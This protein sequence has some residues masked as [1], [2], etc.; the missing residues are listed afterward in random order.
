M[1]AATA[2]FRRPIDGAVGAALRVGEDWRTEVNQRNRNSFLAQAILSY[3]VNPY[4]RFTAVPTYLSRVNGFDSTI[5]PAPV[6]GDRSCAATPFG[7]FL[8][9]GLYD[10][11]F[12][13]P[14]GLSLAL[15]PSITV[16]GEVIPRT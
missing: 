13:V 6:P 3:T 14:V 15:T 8:C 16:H 11:I 4:V 12:N 9:S 5:Y 7:N 10:D 1:H 2:Q